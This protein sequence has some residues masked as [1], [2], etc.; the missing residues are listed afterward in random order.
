MGLREWFERRRRERE[1][2]RRLGEAFRD[3]AL[4]AGTS[5]GPRH[6]GRWV[7]LEEEWAEGRLARIRFGIVRHP[8]PY[9][10]SRQSHQVLEVY[11]YDLQAGRITVERGRN[12][13]RE[14]G[15][16]AD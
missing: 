3:P 10:F 11:L 2:R 14:G 8:R 4:L 12:L 15:R 16:D 9:P 7:L 13:T 1:A 6:A 5:L